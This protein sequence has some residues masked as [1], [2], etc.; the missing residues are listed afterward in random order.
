M[1]TWARGV[2]LPS[3]NQL[4]PK[5]ERPRT[6]KKNGE[7][8]LQLLSPQGLTP[9]ELSFSRLRPWCLYIE[10]EWNDYLELEN[11]FGFGC[12]RRLTLV[13][14]RSLTPTTNS[15]AWILF[16][17]FLFAVLR[18]LKRPSLHGNTLRFWFKS[19]KLTKCS[20]AT[21]KCE[22]NLIIKLIFKLGR[23]TWTGQLR[24][25]LESCEFEDP[26]WYFCPR[27]R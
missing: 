1:S 6:K 11:V 14:S 13:T 5:A 15:Y 9:K 21:G 27:E 2:C 23:T 17:H 19:Q 10:E 3:D 20:E 7:F 25:K 4:N 16:T 12:Y 26:T 8:L 24:V 18:N 22:S